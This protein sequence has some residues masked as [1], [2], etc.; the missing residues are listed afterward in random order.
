MVRLR[1]GIRVS[2]TPG[3][4]FTAPSC[5]ISATPDPLSE[6]CSLDR[7]PAYCFLAGATRHRLN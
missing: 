4:G 2:T 3:G 7:R 5:G 1:I 6:G